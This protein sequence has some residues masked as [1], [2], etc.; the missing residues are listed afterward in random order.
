VSRKHAITISVAV[1]LAAIAGTVAATKTIELSPAAAEPGT[2]SHGAI[3]KRTAA[4]DRAEI[5]LRNALKERPPKL[6]PLPR[7]LPAARAQA[8]GSSA[9]GRP[10]VATAPRVV[11]V[12]PAPIIRR[13]PRA[14][15]ENELEH[16]SEHLSASQSDHGERDDFD[17]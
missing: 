5:A 15:D 11:Y 2:A 13:A 8:G 6:P 1:G 17:D 14:D 10:P 3:A 9:T 12:R 4:L 16:E 7:R